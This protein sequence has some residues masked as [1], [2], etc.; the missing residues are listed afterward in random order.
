M[1]NFD[2]FVTRHFNGY[3]AHTLAQFLRQFYPS[4]VVETWI[5]KIYLCYV[6]KLPEY[7]M[8]L[9][10]HIQEEVYEKPN[11]A[12]EIEYFV[13]NFQELEYSLANNIPCSPCVFLKE[14]A[15]EMYLNG[16]ITLH[17]FKLIMEV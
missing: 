15:L 4:D 5:D 2:E 13:L 6:G 7:E 14:H 10:W 8:S 12:R 16:T 1:M 3:S 17:Q 11:L 9:F